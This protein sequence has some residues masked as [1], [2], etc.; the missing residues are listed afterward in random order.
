MDT[1]PSGPWRLSKKHLSIWQRSRHPLSSGGLPS[2]W[3]L[4]SYLPPPTSR[5]PLTSRPLGYLAPRDTSTSGVSRPRG[6]LRPLGYLD[7]WG[8]STSGVPPTSR[9]PPTSEVPCSH[10]PPAPLLPSPGQCPHHLHLLLT[11]LHAPV[12]IFLP[13]RKVPKGR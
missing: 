6:Y 1:H 7:L 4:T 5:V 2:L 11:V 12:K 8:T 13:Q 10:P 9:V 3:N